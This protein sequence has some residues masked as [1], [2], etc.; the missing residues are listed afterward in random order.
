M[1]LIASWL[2][3]GQQQGAS[4]ASGLAGLSIVIKTFTK[5]NPKI[6]FFDV[7]CIFFYW[8]LQL[9]HQQLLLGLPIAVHA[10]LLP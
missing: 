6:N 10:W 4:F 9:L 5:M 8:L 2:K 1:I 7:T 3:P